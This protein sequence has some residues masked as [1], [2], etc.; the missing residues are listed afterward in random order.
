MR[1]F[2]YRRRVD[3]DAK[4]YRRRRTSEFP[5]R[6]FKSVAGE[7]IVGGCL[8]CRADSRMQAAGAAIVRLLGDTMRIVYSPAAMERAAHASEV[9]CIVIISVTIAVTFLRNGP[10]QGVPHV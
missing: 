7:V 3:P 5:E 9:I 6:M 8:S 4:D 10:R 1:L 2:G